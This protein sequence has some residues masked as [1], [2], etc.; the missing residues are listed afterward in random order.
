MD[1]RT[2]QWVNSIHHYVKKGEL[3]KREPEKS[4]NFFT[5]LPTYLQATIYCAGGLIV[6]TVIF[7]TY[8]SIKQKLL[9]KTRRASVIAFTNCNEAAKEE[10]INEYAAK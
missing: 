4:S 8:Y 6:I 3:T 5:S 9:V 10:I 1:T 7:L 2:Y